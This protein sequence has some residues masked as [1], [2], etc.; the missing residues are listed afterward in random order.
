MQFNIKRETLLK[1]LQL[2]SNVIERKQTMPALANVLIDIKGDQLFLTAT[3]LETELVSWVTLDKPAANSG[4]TTVSA[5]KLLDICRVLPD[6]TM[7]DLF[8]D[9]N[10]RFVVRAQKSRFSLGSMPAEDFPKINWN[11]EENSKE[12]SIAQN[13]LY[14]LLESA[15]F[16][17][18]Q[19][20][21]RYY[22]N[23]MLFEIK[24][25]MLWVVASDGHRM[26]I[27]GI[28][29]EVIDNS[30]TRVIVPYKGIF[31]LMRLL[32]D[33]DEPVVIAV[34]AN[35]IR[36]TGSQFIFT[37]KLIDSKYAEYEKAIPHGCDKKIVIEREALKQALTRVA[38]L[39]NDVFCSAQLKITSDNIRLR[40]NN[41]D[42]EEAE[43]E[44]SAEYQGEAINTNFNIGYLLDI[45]KNIRSE[46]VV[47]TLKDGFSSALVQ[48]Q[49]EGSNL[50]YIVMPLR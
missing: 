40:T 27:N 49:L 7:V 14:M 17:M 10:S 3:D 9:S 33:S 6:E 31:G 38:I 34:G 47:L 35:H 30:L 23:G 24:N 26:A 8:Q 22:L 5:R 16:A 36:V 18:A 46:K 48:E 42:H 43:E 13:K 29:Q 4:K 50:I 37:S 12:F 41:P 45:L 21:A 11:S 44:I 19:Q 20:D 25:A 28:E 1:P 39:S 15:R 2:L 32:T